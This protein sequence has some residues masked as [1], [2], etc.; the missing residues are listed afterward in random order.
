MATAPEPV[1]AV[2][3][4]RHGSAASCCSTFYELDWVRSLAEDIFHPGGEA[5]TRKTVSAMNL[6][7]GA[8]VADLG[9][10]TGTSAMLLAEE[11]D[12]QV[13]AVDIS[14]ANIERAKKRAES[15]GDRIRFLQA[16]AQ[17]L[18]F[19]PQQFD[20]ALAE[21]TF[22]LFPDQP[23][24][25]REIHRVL[26]P[27]GQ[28]AV[29]D[30]A[31]GGRLP[32]DIAAVLAPWTCLADAV[33]QDTYVERFEKE[34]FSVVEISDES[35]ALDHLVLMLKCKLMLLGMGGM[36]ANQAVPDFEPAVIRHW[37]NRF[38]EEVAT[39]TIRYQRFQLN[40]KNGLIRENE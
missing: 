37:L 7:A 5:L 35:A 14:A 16:D 15:F 1:S 17:S 23:R 26:K 33:S 25:L 32:D 12:L 38:G 21:C 39:G 9:C 2:R 20:A 19:A 22:S 30:M 8:S 13:S 31:T 6:P 18:P 10:G 11:F 29:T 40:R 3:P 27:D 34:G 28:L 4:Q 24:A 36:M